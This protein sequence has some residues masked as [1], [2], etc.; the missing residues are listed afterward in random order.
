MI[1]QDFVFLAGSTFSIVVL[2]PTLRNSM[3]RVPLGTSVPSCLIGLLYGV[4]FLTMDMTFSA[5]G[6]LLTGVLWALIASVRSPRG[7][8]AAA[9]LFPGR[10][11]SDA[12]ASRAASPGAD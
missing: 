1:W 5:V 2:A 6:S 8:E 11:R 9:A 4:T 10:F 7:R 3:A 12:D